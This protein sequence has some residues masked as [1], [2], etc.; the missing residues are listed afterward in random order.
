MLSNEADAVA[1][2]IA[3][4]RGRALIG[5]ADFGWARGCKKACGQLWVGGTLTVLHVVIIGD[6]VG[7]LAAGRFGRGV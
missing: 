5:R 2:S 7:R 4:E 3:R 1:G 6:P